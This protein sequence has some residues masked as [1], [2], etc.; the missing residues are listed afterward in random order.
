MPALSSDHWQQFLEGRI[1]GLED[2]RKRF[3]R[4][5]KAPRC[6]LCQAPFEGI[7]GRLLRF[8]RF[9]RWQANS[10]LC[11]IC[12][13]SLDKS[14]GGVEIEA[15][16]VFAD[17][18]GSTGVAER[19]RPAEFH[20]ILERFYRVAAMAIDDAGG[21]VDKFLGD[22]VVAFFVPVFAGEGG[23]A[24]SAIRAGQ[25]I[26]AGVASGGTGRSGAVAEPWLPVGVGV[27]TGLAFVGVLGTEGGQLD[28]TG[29]GDAVNTAARLGSVAEAG[30]LLVS[31]ASAARAGLDTT[32]L[33]H[34]TLELKGREE[35]IEVVVLGVRAAVAA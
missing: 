21:L 11:S 30:E 1:D 9:R 23:P 6:K 4:L 29:V 16:F 25:A 15:T 27:H 31:V 2:M 19:V 14:T 34:R 32:G 8:T 35:P 3:R 33:E 26:L 13:G 18:R 22:G 20:A 12:V 5:P 17:I 28:F 10:T 7:G 24:A